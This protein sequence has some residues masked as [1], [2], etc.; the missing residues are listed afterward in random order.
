MQLGSREPMLAPVAGQGPRFQR[1]VFVCRRA[2]FSLGIEIRFGDH[3]F[4]MAEAMYP[5]RH[6]GKGVSEKSNYLYVELNN[7]C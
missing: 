4:A 3:R 5:G 1:V 7:M 2:P 6:G